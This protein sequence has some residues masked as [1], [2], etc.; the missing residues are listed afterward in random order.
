MITYYAHVC[1][2]ECTR[3]THIYTAYTYE[4]K[5]GEYTVYTRGGY[6]STI[7]GH[8]QKEAI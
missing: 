7:F 4:R 5:I 6:T 3:P 1:T 2:D 8:A